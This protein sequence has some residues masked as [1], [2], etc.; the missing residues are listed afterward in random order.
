VGFITRQTG[1][2]LL[3]VPGT[4]RNVDYEKMAREATEELDVEVLVADPDLPEGD[5]S[6]LGPPAAATATRCAGSSTRRDAVAD[7]KGAA[8][9]LEHRRRQPRHAVVAAV[10]RRTDRVAVVFPITH[11][12]GVVW[13]FN[14]METGAELLLVEVFS[15][16]D[17][18]RSSQEACHGRPAGTV[19]W[20]A[21]LAARKQPDQPLFPKCVLRA[22]ASPSRRTSTTS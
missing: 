4:F 6:T 19:F 9:G 13:M 21:Y 10:R 20:Q 3:V 7:P 17:A 18:R 5:P 2:R 16:D 22:V 12:G 11:V 8:H 15:A 1:C 14:T